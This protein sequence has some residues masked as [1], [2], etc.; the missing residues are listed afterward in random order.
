[1]TIR[2]WAAQNGWPN[3]AGKRGRLSA[4]IHAAYNSW[5]AQQG[6]NAQ[7]EHY[8]TTAPRK[9]ARKVSDYGKCR[10]GSRAVLIYSGPT[11]R[12]QS[13]CSNCKPK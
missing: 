10:C 5:V 6:R 3:V 7:T 12:A 8:A 4:E 2:E 13:L 1:M 11:G 9:V